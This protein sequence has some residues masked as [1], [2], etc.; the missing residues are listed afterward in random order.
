MGNDR[1]GDWID[2]GP[3]PKASGGELGAIDPYPW[4][5]RNASGIFSIVPNLILLP[6]GIDRAGIF[7][8]LLVE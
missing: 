4:L 3:T 7:I 5:T 8:I 6:E 1:T 2:D